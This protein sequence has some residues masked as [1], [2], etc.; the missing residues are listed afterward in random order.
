VRHLASFTPLHQLESLQ[1]AG[2]LPMQQ[3]PADLARLIETWL[4]AEV[5]TSGS[6]PAAI[7]G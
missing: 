3:C 7:T 5:H 1:G 2:H 4:Q 6:F